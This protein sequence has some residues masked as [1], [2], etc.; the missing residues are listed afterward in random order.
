MKKIFLFLT[1]LVT[2]YTCARCGE[3]TFAEFFMNDMVL[4]SGEKVPVWGYGEPGTEI[5]LALLTAVFEEN[6]ISLLEMPPYRGKVDESGR[7]QININPSAPGG[8][9]VLMLRAQDGS[10]IKIENVIFGDVFLFIGGAELARKVA[11]SAD[12]VQELKSSRL[13]DL[14]LFNIG[15]DWAAERQSV[16]TGGWKRSN[17]RNAAVFS[18]TG[19]SCG[20]ELCRRLGYPV[21]VIEMDFAGAPVSAWLSRDNLPAEACNY[22]ASYTQDAVEQGKL[23]LEFGDSMEV[24]ASETPPYSPHEPEVLF[25]GMTAPILPAALKAVVWYPESV[26]DKWLADSADIVTR[27]IG[28]IRG[29]FNNPELP[30]FIILSADKALAAAQRAAAE[31]DSRIFI[32]DSIGDSAGKVTADMIMAELYNNEEAKQ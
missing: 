10:S 20:A 16:L 5:E 1:L 11:S 4:Q 9:S 19:Y 21:G 30:I 29:S 14:R 22:I 23:K 13:A 3:T 27:M 31:R 26:A 18:Q 15:D 2:W 8:Q 17:P 28:N 6:G 25:N 12:A 7:W 32:V 24:A